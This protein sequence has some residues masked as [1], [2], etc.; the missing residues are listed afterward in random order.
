[1]TLKGREPELKFVK[2]EFGIDYFREDISNTTFRL[3]KDKEWEI[4]SLD[5]QTFNPFDPSTSSIKSQFD[6]IASIPVSWEEIN[7]PRHYGG[8]STYE[9]IKVI[10]AWS[11]GFCLG[12][13]LKY[14]KRA[15]QKGGLDDLKKAMWY[16]EREIRNREEAAGGGAEKA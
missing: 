7:H 2:R 11:L 13:V 10:E 6:N 15:D 1:M 4:L 5:G 8:D 12:N 14:I 16:L 3:T 9:A